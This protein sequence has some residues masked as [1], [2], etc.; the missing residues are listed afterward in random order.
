V[1]LQLLI[2]W[3]SLPEVRGIDLD[4]GE[5]LAAHRS[6]LQR[7][8]FLRRFYV[9]QYRVFVREAERLRAH[10][11]AMLELGS[12]A[13]FLKDLLP[14]VITSEL[15]QAPGVDR[16]V[17]ADR[18]PFETG[19]LK[20]IFL[21]NVLHHIADPEAFFREA[22]RCLILGGRVVMVEPAN[23]MLGGYFY[24]RLHHEPFDEHA[25]SWEIRGQGRLTTSNPALPWIIFSRDRDRFERLFP[26]LKICVEKRHT[27]FCFLL[28]GGLSYR[29]MV[30]GFLYPLFA[31]IDRRLCRAS[32]IF[33]LFQTVVMERT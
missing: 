18:L 14:E 21:L 20:A 6:I 5:A 7:K 2:R 11:G 8:L 19:S 25:C 30:P 1:N 28:S 29:S 13:G 31:G 9:D 10:P 32:A 24:K 33:P 16:V 26:S 27:F 17:P 23:T 22:M 3:L 4:S 12:G 15:I